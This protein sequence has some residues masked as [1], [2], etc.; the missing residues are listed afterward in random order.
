MV[1]L[2]TVLASW[3]VGSF[4]A[5]GAVAALFRGRSDRVEDGLAVVVAC[6]AFWRS[7]ARVLLTLRRFLRASFG[8][9]SRSLKTFA[10]LVTQVL[11]RDV[12]G[13]Y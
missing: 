5:V 12:G 6:W 7:V 10:H 4:R 2:P 8:V 9:M 13:L 1:A 11:E 3:A